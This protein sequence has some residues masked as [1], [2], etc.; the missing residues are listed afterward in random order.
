MERDCIL[1]SAFDRISDE[2]IFITLGDFNA[3]IYTQYGNQN[4]NVSNRRGKILQEFI[5]ERL[6]L[7][8]N[9]QTYATGENF[10]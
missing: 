9:S 6:L 8:V 10:T 2:Y 5:D 7:S 4:H 3:Q 1:E